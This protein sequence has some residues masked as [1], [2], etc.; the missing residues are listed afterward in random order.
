MELQPEEVVVAA[1][2]GAQITEAFLADTAHLGAM[3][4]AT[5]PVRALPSALEEAVAQIVL[6]RALQAGSNTPLAYKVLAAAFLVD[7]SKFL[8]DLPKGHLLELSLRIA[9]LQL[10]LLH[11]HY[12]FVS[13]LWKHL[14]KRDVPNESR[15]SFVVKEYLFLILISIILM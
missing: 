9:Q 14:V 12:H 8:L 4:L 5:E 13:H 1:E 6:R 11:Y 10:P 3:C 2:A 7:Q 15:I